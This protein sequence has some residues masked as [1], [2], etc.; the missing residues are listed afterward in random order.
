M[1]YRATQASQEIG[2][3]DALGIPTCA[4]GLPAGMIFRGALPLPMV[5]TLWPSERFP[6]GRLDLEPTPA[7]MDAAEQLADALLAALEQ[8]TSP[9]PR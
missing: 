5:S 3:R 6:M 2:G 8:Q 1:S 9:K 7:R 4:T